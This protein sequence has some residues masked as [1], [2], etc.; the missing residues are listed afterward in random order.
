MQTLTQ[1]GAA[2]G[3]V[4]VLFLFYVGLILLPDYFRRK[5]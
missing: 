4:V 2:T 1:L 3:L 5:R